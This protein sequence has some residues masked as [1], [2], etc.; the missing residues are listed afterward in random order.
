MFIP[1]GAYVALEAQFLAAQKLIKVV[2]VSCNLV[3][4][5]PSEPDE[6]RTDSGKTSPREAG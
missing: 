1:H 2:Y 5:R 4:S 6:Q 3:S